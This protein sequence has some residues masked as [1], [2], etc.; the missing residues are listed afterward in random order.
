MAD[1][2]QKKKNKGDEATLEMTPM[3]DVVFQLLIFFIVTLN[4]PDILSQLEA[5]R[6]APNPSPQEVVDP[7]SSITI[8]GF[9]THPGLGAYMFGNDQNRRTVTLEQLRGFA[10]QMARANRNQSVVVNCT[11][12]APHGCLVRVLDLL[13]DAGLRSVSVFSLDNGSEKPW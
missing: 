1:K 11:D 9:K 13:A 2:K 8:K 6:P 10:A 12:S 3:I 5:L 4:Q 7:P